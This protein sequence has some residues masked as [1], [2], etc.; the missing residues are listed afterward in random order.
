M[1]KYKKLL[2]ATSSVMMFASSPASAQAWLNNIVK[3]A[4]NVGNTVVNGATNTGNTVANGATSTSTT[5]ANATTDAVAQGAGYGNFAAAQANGYTDS[6]VLQ[7]ASVTASANQWSSLAAADTASQAMGFAN[8]A[9]RMASDSA[10]V[11]AANYTALQ[12]QVASG[13]STMSG[14]YNKSFFQIESNA[15]NIYKKAKDT[16]IGTGTPYSL[17]K[18]FTERCATAA[19]GTWGSI[20]PYVSKAKALDE[21]AKKAL[22]RLLRTM[23]RGSKPD[24]QTGADMRT[25]GQALGFVTA[26]G[27]ALAGNAYQS[28]F[29][30]SIGGS[31]GWVAGANS[32]ISFAM[33]TFPTNG[34]YY[35]TAAVSGGAQLAAGTGD[36]EPGATIGFGLGWAPGSANQSG[37]TLTAGGTAS[38]VDVAAT[39]P[40]PTTL[41]QVLVDDMVNNP[42][43]KAT[44]K[45]PISTPPFVSVKTVTQPG[46]TAASLAAT[47]TPAV[48]SQIDAVC[49]APGV[50]VGVS[51]PVPQNLGN[52]TFSVGYTNVVWTGAF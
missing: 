25:V 35:M 17:V 3:K 37:V 43:V 29:S 48:A 47:L 28:N 44:V 6:T 49:Q 38:G 42:P 50:S 46:N 14:L 15:N 23:A 30:I 20:T 1:L 36:L 51:I 24:Q 31:G 34:K 18:Y 32:S 9:Q 13:V 16:L 19:T 7:A 41:A 5:A 4:T 40:V 10:A 21:N 39:W 45:Q 2:C 26:N 33:D 11:D 8:Y 27:F 52:V 12:G 22:Y